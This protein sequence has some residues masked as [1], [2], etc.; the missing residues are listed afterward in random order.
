MRNYEELIQSANKAMM[1]KLLENEHKPSWKDINLKDLFSFLFFE[2]EELNTEVF[3]NSD[4][5]GRAARIRRE[6]ADVA[7]YA[8][9]IIELC[10]EMIAQLEVSSEHCENK[11]V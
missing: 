9:M 10:D 8:A 11:T 1:E 6:A 7:N 5:P 4:V 3:Y 2:M